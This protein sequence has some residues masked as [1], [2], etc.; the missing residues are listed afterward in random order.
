MDEQESEKPFAIEKAKTG[1]AKCK[2]CKL[3]IDKDTVRI[4]KLMANPFGEGKMKAWHHVTCL[5]EVFAKQRATTR[6]LEDPEEDVDGWDHLEEEDKKIVIEHLE[7]FD[8]NAP[9]KKKRS[10]SPPKNPPAKKRKSSPPPAAKETPENSSPKNQ[11]SIK[12]TTTEYDKKSENRDNAFR[13][14]RRVCANIA[15][16]SAYTEKTAIVKKMFSD[17][18]KGSKS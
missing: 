15:N 2:K 16:A 14:F 7:E 8:K 3:P 4:A 13:E 12:N 17:G 11:D 10:S 18:A 1:R 9:F 6:R 5:F